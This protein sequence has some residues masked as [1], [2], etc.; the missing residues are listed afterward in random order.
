MED[1]KR[2][3]KAYSNNSKKTRLKRRKN[4]FQRIWDPEKQT[5]VKVR[6]AKFPALK[7]LK[8]K[9]WRE[10]DESSA[11][12]RRQ[13]S[14]NVPVKATKP[15][16]KSETVQVKKKEAARVRNKVTTALGV[17]QCDVQRIKTYKIHGTNYTWDEKTLLY[18]KA[19]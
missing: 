1:E 7:P 13:K 16:A 15:T 17:V 9:D 12:K 3:V 10:A 8:R 11:I 18:K 14:K 6:K 4:K 2:I 5:Y 19:A